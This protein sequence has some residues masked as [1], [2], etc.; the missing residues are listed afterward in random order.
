MKK[1]ALCLLSLLCL[2]ANANTNISHQEMIEIFDALGYGYR[3]KQND[4]FK[5]D[6]QHIQDNYC[7]LTTD[8]IEFYKD[9]NHDGFYEVMITGFDVDRRGAIAQNFTLLTKDTL[10][11]ENKPT[12]RTIASEIGKATLLD[13]KG[14][15]NYPQIQ[16]NAKDYCNQPVYS[17]QGVAYEPMMG[18]CYSSE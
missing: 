2:S 1:L 7:I 9:I 18:I 17:Y 11:N 6:C 13:S 10:L 5:R 4:F 3:T 8:N 14:D 12:Y 15:E 16:V